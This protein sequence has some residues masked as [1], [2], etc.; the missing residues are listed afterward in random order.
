MRS[1]R[2]KSQ[3]TTRRRRCSDFIERRESEVLSLKLPIRRRMSWPHM[4]GV[5]CRLSPARIRWVLTVD[6]VDKPRSETS[7]KRTPK[8]EWK[9]ASLALV[10]SSAILVVA[11]L[12]ANLQSPRVALALLIS[13]IAA[14]IIFALVSA[15]VIRQMRKE[16]ARYELSLKTGSRSFAKWPTTFRKSS[17]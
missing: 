3:W 8:R 13:L 12:V 4:V 1:V 6:P 9:I 5:S 15:D 11:V 2:E 7:P 10:V 16:N 17:G 14:M